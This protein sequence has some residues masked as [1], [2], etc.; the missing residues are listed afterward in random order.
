MI[1]FACS[2]DSHQ[3]RNASASSL[4][5]AAQLMNFCMSF[6]PGKDRV[7]LTGLS[8]V[9]VNVDVSWVA[10]SVTTE[11]F[12]VTRPRA[13]FCLPGRLLRCFLVGFFVVVLSLSPIAWLL[14]HDV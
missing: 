11:S 2:S 4:S 7:F 9:A 3:A 8:V 1:V 14:I 6:L 5:S 12:R 13:L 10:S